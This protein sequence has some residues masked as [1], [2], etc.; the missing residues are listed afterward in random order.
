MKA[1]SCA[2]SLIMPLPNSMSPSTQAVS[3]FL[4]SSVA[5][6]PSSGPVSMCA[7]QIK[8]LAVAGASAGWPP[9]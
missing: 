6:G 3:S 2:L 7:F 4:S 9:H 1:Q 8:T 5:S